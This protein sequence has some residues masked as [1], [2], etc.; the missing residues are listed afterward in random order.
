MTSGERV[1]EYTCVCCGIP[2]K[3]TPA[4]GY[5]M[6]I[7]VLDI[8]AD[9]RPDRVWLDPD[10]CVI[11]ERLFFVKGLLDIPIHGVKE[12]L[13]WGLWVTQTETELN[14]YEDARGTDRTGVVTRGQITVTMPGYAALDSNGKN[15]LLSCDLVGQPKGLRPVI[16]L[17][18]SEH[19][20]YHDH[21][22]GISWEKATE[23]VAKVPHH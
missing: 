15:H 9:E 11:D 19:V 18:P 4:F 1:F 17:S 23:L 6:P 2:R 8:P 3:G 13:S 14:A 21:K 10:I 16:N 20:L 12:P 22:F 5:D 7:E